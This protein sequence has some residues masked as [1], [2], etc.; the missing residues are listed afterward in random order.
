MEEKKTATFSAR[1]R[2]ALDDKGMKQADLA[3]ATGMCSAAISRYLSGEYEPK[4]K[5]IHKLATAL[6]V[7][8]F[9]LYG[10]EVPRE[11][12]EEQKKS[13]HLAEVVAKLRNDS[14]FFEVV[15]ILASLP[16]EEYASVKLLLTRLG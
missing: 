11:R 6:S 4:Q 5:A 16:P 1:L 9:W 12:S 8:E 14:E 15:S 3:R 10:F 7:S 13:D 2:E